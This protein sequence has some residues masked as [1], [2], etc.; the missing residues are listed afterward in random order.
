MHV[1]RA[2]RRK[3]QKTVYYQYCKSQKGHYSYQNWWELTTFQLDLKYSKIKSYVK[4]QLNMSKHVS[5]KCG[6][7]S[8]SRILSYKSGRTPTKIDKNWRHSNLIKCSLE[9]SDMQNFKSIGKAY[10]R[11]ACKRKVR[12]TVFFQYFKFQKGHH[13]YKNWRKLTTLKLDL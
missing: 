12:K 7:L 9:E 11:K 4:F 13:S 10:R 3:V 8:I 2:C 5:E 6:I 1:G